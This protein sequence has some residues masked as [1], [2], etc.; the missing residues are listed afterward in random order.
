M[1]LSLVIKCLFLFLVT[2]EWRSCSAHSFLVQPKGDFKSFKKAE[3][4]LGGPPHAP[5]DACSG[6]CINMNSWQYDKQVTVTRYQ[7]GQT[8]SMKWGRNNHIGGFVRFSLV[9]KHL[10]MNKQ[11]HERMAFRYACFESG[12]HQCNLQNCGTDVWLYKTNVVIPTSYPDG[13]YI[14][15]WAWFGGI[16][17]GKSY[18]GDYYSCTP[19]RIQG[20]PTTASYTPIFE[21]GENLYNSSR[22]RTAVDRLGICVREPCRG[23]NEKK[24]KPYPFSENRAPAP[25]RASWMNQGLS[26]KSGTEPTSHPSNSPTPTPS[27]SGKPAMPTNSSV[28]PGITA[29][30]L[31]NVKTK[32][33][34]ARATTYRSAI[35]VPRWITSFTIVAETQGDVRSVEF[36]INGVRTR[37]ENVKPYSAWGDYRNV[38]NPWPNPKFYTWVKVRMV[39][40]TRTLQRKQRVFLIRLTR[41]G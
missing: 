13:N 15:S 7:R 21:G 19:V 20:G 32:A 33:R 35:A 23:H 41:S 16:S 24:M 2:N 34:F 6:P 28:I 4:R 29:L 39:L 8:V 37:T 14:L 31:I 1:P 30:S 11:A 3:C 10:R 17:V 38:Y 40:I 12:K 27:V 18:F 22:C 5:N 25:I 26:D 36:S 9:P